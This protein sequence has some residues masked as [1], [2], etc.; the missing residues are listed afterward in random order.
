MASYSVELSPTAVGEWLRL[1]TR[2][3]RRAAD[4]AMA[5]LA[6]SRR[7]AGSFQLAGETV[8]RL[9]REDV[10]V[11]YVPT[12]AGAFVTEIRSR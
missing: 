7:P 2:A 4:R 11:F 1:P 8:W 10:V 9:V 5:E 3:Q 12:E 6:Q